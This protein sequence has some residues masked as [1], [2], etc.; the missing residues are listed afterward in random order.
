[1]TLIELLVVVAI[2]G[3]MIGLLLPAVQY[4]RESG[5]RLQCMN[6]MRQ[7][8]LA[9]T[10]FAS[11]ERH[12]PSAAISKEYPTKP[13]WPHTFYRWSAL[14]QSLP[15]LEQENV[16]DLL[17]L[18]IPLY[19][20]GYV[21]S[22]RN[23]AGIAT[24]LPVFLCAS[25][26]RQPVQDGFGPTNYAVCAGTGAGGG[27]PFDTDGMFFVNSAT[28]YAD[29]TDGTSH[30]VMLSESLLGEDTKTSGGTFVGYTP[31][32]SYKFAFSIFGG[33]ELSD[34]KCNGSANYNTL[35]TRNGPRGFAWCSGEYRSATYNHYYAPNSPICDCMNSAATDP[36][37]GVSKPIL[38]SAY[39]WRSARSWHPGGVNV[40]LADGSGHFV[41]N[42]VDLIVWR[43]MSTR[44]KSDATGDEF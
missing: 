4:A 13:E 30:T 24:V 19:L 18:S 3:V 14:A 31:E 25:D 33:P 21:V 9:L 2:I 8:G 28:K 35:T 41:E 44:S 39:G 15:Y 10:N 11:S 12:F 17:D 34:F 5:R 6:N 32:R 23:K 7:V 20:P 22:E 37:I 16:L 43:G 1:M 38:N 27:T 29:I 42:S 26:I 36:T 40:I